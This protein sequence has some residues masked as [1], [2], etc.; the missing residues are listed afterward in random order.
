MPVETMTPRER[1][2]AVLRHEQPDRVPMDYWSTPEFERKLLKHLGCPDARAMFKA[3]HIDRPVTVAPRYVGPPLEP[4]TDVFGIHYTD[5]TYGSGSYAEATVPPLALCS[6]VEEI[7]ASYRWPCPDWWAYDE[8]PLQLQ[9]L[10]EYPVQGGGSEPLMTYADLR[11]REQAMLDFV[12][13]PDIVQ[14]CLDK[15]FALAYQNTLRILE[16]LPGKVT[17]CYIAEDLGGQSNLMYSP[18]HIRC[19]LFPGMKRMIDLAHQAGAYA[20][21]HDDGTITRILPELVEL[22]IDVLNPIQWRAAGMDRETLKR[23]YG[24]RLVFHGA[25]DNQQT[26]PFAT[27]DAVR[28]EV[29]DNLRLLGHGGGYVLAPCHNL[30]VVSPV[31]NV[32][33]MYETGYA[34]GWL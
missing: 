15:L 28:Q 1:W 10:E 24:S 23:Q 29:R 9:G 34:E 33:A 14:Y 26:L 6:S 31:E 4:G 32:L 2:L 22:G 19:F 13:H 30:Q 7:Q 20:F 8:L 5:I 16:T 3:L 27:P 11:G 17:Y 18:R 21:H 25:M 12:E